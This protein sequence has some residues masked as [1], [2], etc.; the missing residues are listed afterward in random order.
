VPRA[1]AMAMKAAAS[2]LRS[3]RRLSSAEFVTG[4]IGKALRRNGRTTIK[5][6]PGPGAAWSRDRDVP[7]PARQSFRTW[8]RK[9]GGRA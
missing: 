2:T 9:T 3:H 5:W 6:A 1:E 8:W 4:L 7:A